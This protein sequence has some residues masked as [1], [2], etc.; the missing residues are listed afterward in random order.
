MNS[1]KLL[2]ALLAIVM[3]VQ[4][5]GLEAIAAEIE[6]I[7]SIS[8]ENDALT[9]DATAEET[10][11]FIL[12]EDTDK[13]TETSK[14]FVMSDGTYEVALYN[15]AVHYED[16]NGNWQ[17][18]DNTL[19]STA[20]ARSASAGKYVNRNNDVCVEFA[21]DAQSDELFRYS[22]DDYSL[23]WSIPS[24]ASSVGSLLNYQT[25][26]DDETVVETLSSGIRYNNIFENVDIEYEIYG[27][28]IKE[29]IIINSV[30][31][32]YEYTFNIT[33]DGVTLSLDANGN[34]IG[35]I[36][37]EQ[38]F[39]IPAPFMYDA[40]G[41][42]SYDV[43][44]ELNANSSISSE[45]ILTISADEAWIESDSTSFPVI[46]DPLVESEI[47]A[48]E[49]ARID[50]EYPEQIINILTAGHD[51]SGN[52]EMSFYKFNLPTL[53]KG[54]MVVN[55]TLTLTQTSSGNEIS[56]SSTPLLYVK[57]VENTW[58]SS[59]MCWNTYAADSFADTRNAPILDYAIMSSLNEQEHEFDITKSVCEWYNGADNNGILLQTADLPDGDSM[60]VQFVASGTGA[61]CVTIQYRNARGLEDYWSYQG[62]NCGDY[63]TVFVNEYNGNPVVVTADLFTSGMLLPVSLSHVYNGYLAG[64]S[65]TERQVFSSTYVGYG[66]K[67]NVQEVLGFVDNNKVI[68]NDADGTQHYLL[69]EDSETVFHDEDGLGLELESVDGNYILTDAYGTKRNFGSGGYL[70]SIEDANGNIATF[71]YTNSRITKITDG[72]GKEIDFTYNTNGRLLSIADGDG[73][74]VEYTYTSGNLTGVTYKKNTETIYTITYTYTNNLLDG[75]QTSDSKQVNLTYTSDSSSK[76]ASLSDGTQTLNFEYSIDNSQ[77]SYYLESTSTDMDDVIGVTAI[78]DRYGTV[79]SE[80]SS[81]LDKSEVYGNVSYEYAAHESSTLG[82]KIAVAA[83]S[84]KATS[85]LLLTRGYEVAFSSLNVNGLANDTYTA[86][87][88]NVSEQYN[89]YGTVSMSVLNDA[90]ISSTS[91][92]DMRQGITLPAGTYTM[93][94]M[95]KA[96]NI[97]G[98]GG[99]YISVNSEMFAETVPT[100]GNSRYVSGTTSED[101][102]RGWQML[103]TTVTL[104]TASTVYAHWGLYNCTGTAYFDAIYLTKGASP[105]EVNLLGNPY[106]ENVDDIFFYWDSDAV[107]SDTISMSGSSL[108][109]EGYPVGG[110]SVSQ[111]VNYYQETDENGNVIYP[112]GFML[113][114]WGKADCTTGMGCAQ[115]GLKA[116]INYGDANNTKQTEYIGFN[117]YCSDWQYTST[118]ICPNYNYP[119]TSITIACVYNATC[120]YAYFD[121][122]CL[123]CT[124]V[125]LYT[126]DEDGNVTSTH[127]SSGATES[128]TYDANGNMLTS[129]DSSGNTTTYTYDENGN[130]LSAVDSLGISTNYGY[131]SDGNVTSTIITGNA[132][133]S[134]PTLFSKTDY[135][136]DGNYI[137]SSTDERGKTTSYTYYTDENGDINGQVKSI[138]D[139]NGNTICYTYYSDGNVKDVFL[140]LNNNGT[141]DSGETV[142]TFEYDDTQT[143]IAHNSFEYEIKTD[144]SGNVIEI[145]IGTINLIEYEYVY[146]LDLSDDLDRMDIIFN[147]GSINSSTPETVIRYI[148][149]DF[150][151]VVKVQ[152]GNTATLADLYEWIYDSNGN[153]YHYIDYETDTITEFEY[154]ANGN[155]VRATEY[156]SDDVNSNVLEV[157]SAYDSSSKCIWQSYK[158]GSEAAKVYS[159]T[160]DDYDR[161]QCVNLPNGAKLQNYTDDLNR[162]HADRIYNSDGTQVA[163]SFISR[164]V[165]GADSGLGTDNNSAT[166]N[167]PETVNLIAGSQQQHYTYSYDSNGN[168]TSILRDLNYETKYTYDELNRLVREDNYDADRSYTYTYD[169]G[170]NITSV[171]EYAYTTGT[172]GAVLDTVSYGYANSVWKDMLT[173]FDGQSISYAASGL[174]MMYRDMTMMWEGRE[175]SD[176]LTADSK[177]VYYEYDANG[178]RTKKTV[179]GVI[180]EYVWLGDMLIREQTGTNVTYYLYDENGSVIGFEYNGTPYYYLK[181][182]QGDVVSI[183]DNSGVVVVNYTYNAWGEIISTTG[184]LASTI[185]A[186]NKLRYRSY[187]CDTETGFYYL[188]SRYYDPIVKRFISP[189]STDYL[190]ENG[191][192]DG[193]NLYAYCVN[194]P[195]MYVDS[196]GT[197]SINIM[198]KVIAFTVV[199]INTATAISHRS[200]NKKLK[201]PTGYIMGQASLSSY[202]FGLKTLDYNGCGIV[203]TY[204]ALLVLGKY[205]ELYKI[206][207][208]YEITGGALAGGLLGLNPVYVLAFFKCYGYT[209]KT[210]TTLSDNTAKNAK[211]NIILYVTSGNNFH[212]ITVKWNGSRFIAYNVKNQ[213]TTFTAMNSIKS[214]F[215]Y[216]SYVMLYMFSIS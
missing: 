166:S 138:R 90:E 70:R 99:A 189:D 207:Y 2:A 121:N 15:N 106:F 144:S 142:N 214:Y 8:A 177:M 205:V 24:A 102:N 44:Y 54:D 50:E 140:D 202:K 1:K 193:Y 56:T 38:S 158:Y 79:T 59:T 22:A 159:Y 192:F 81:K 18:I 61:P 160:Y 197:I 190:T 33:A 147:S 69:K 154:D 176:L 76:V 196:T 16:T 28:D 62:V 23:T 164:F 170:G 104:N 203:A 5:I 210:S 187:Y 78:F 135:T 10:E 88:Q 14:T 165:D 132:T 86:S 113:S 188:Q 145:N 72:A 183:V 173:S 75:V 85:N 175:L 146:N 35:S 40:N 66:W 181:N 141:C 109:L 105:C 119:I 11:S 21:A 51:T 65:F 184:T 150:G 39:V 163:G 195:V 84:G 143:S 12:F 68:Y 212:Y 25:T 149:D 114:G 116:T 155:A 103:T 48:I 67:M 215:G 123:T 182:I 95:V 4:M 200:S 162:N 151:Q 131:N 91:F 30:C 128:Y 157:I 161:V 178:L 216:K 41:D 77:T 42:I 208:Q 3:G 133:F 194:N 45:Y 122:L 31:D 80:Y 156:D 137:L 37:D 108:K 201:D 107:L 115:F 174:P 179:D 168:I 92:W 100:V 167:L 130:V 7:Q 172:L 19:V 20:T 118:A 89:G 204:N 87:T 6:N 96:E 198:G 83:S 125:T 94:A 55:A 53:A 71:T 98:N 9:T 126:Y 186:V 206:I 139:P 124:D 26:S 136:D 47:S 110:N 129:T 112:T 120:N 134:I 58:A 27:K 209:V 152:E 32:V 117:N 185:G 153:I 127:S 171:K 43:E 63:T 34:I 13:R 111:T 169:A 82:N 36:G 148:Y 49:T 93:Q 52:D 191:D 73:N 97:V 101:I 60:Y 57:Q 74:S 46:I 180:T 29:N 213:N 199:A 17:E 64:N 211:V